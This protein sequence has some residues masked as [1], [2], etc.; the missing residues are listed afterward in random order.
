MKKVMILSREDFILEENQT[1]SL[2]TLK[3]DTMKEEANFDIVAY[4]EKD[5]LII[6]KNRFGSIIPATLNPE[7]AILFS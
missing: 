5:K 2:M 3:P 6:L 7:I 1:P 4:P